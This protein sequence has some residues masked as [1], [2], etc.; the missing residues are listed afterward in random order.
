[1]TRPDGGTRYRPA[2]FRIVSILFFLSGFAGLGYQIIWFKRFSYLWG[3]STLAMAAVVASFLTGLGLGA[4]LLGKLADRVR[5]P[6][7]WYGILEA[8][9]AILALLLP[10]EIRLLT[11]LYEYLYPYLAGQVLSLSAVK[12]GLTFLLLGPPCLLMGGTLPLMLRYFTPAGV[13]LKEFS[14]WLYGLNTLGA[15]TGCYLTGFHLLPALGLHQLNILLAAL[16]L[17]IAAAA[18]VVVRRPARSERPPAHTSSGQIVHGEELHSAE[19]WS[20]YLVTAMTGCAALILEVVW[21]RQLALILG[22]S[23]YAFTAMLFPVLVGIGLGSLVFHCVLA[24]LRRLERLAPLVILGLILSVAVGKWM[25]PSLTAAVGLLKPLRAFE[26]YNG[27]ICVGAS[28]V[29][30]FLP[31]VGMGILFPLF[32]H[33]TRKRAR[34][35]GQ[36]VGVVYGLNIV[37]SVLGSAGASLLLIPRLGLSLSVVVGLLLYSGALVLLF[38]AGRGWRRWLALFACFLL[39]FSA[40]LFSAADVDPRVTNLGMYLYGYYSEQ[41]RAHVEIGYFQEGAAANVLVTRREDTVSLRINGKVEASNT[42]DMTMQLALAYV[43][44]ML[45][46]ESERVLIIGL[47]S[48]T[49]PGAALQFPRTRVTCCEIEPAVL[50]ASTFF[51]EVNHEPHLNPRFSFVADDGRSFLQGTDETFDLILSEPSNPWL[52]GVSNLFTQEFYRLAKKKLNPDGI[53]AQ[54]IQAYSFS[55]ADYRLI[56]RT[57]LSVFPDAR[58]VRVTDGDSILLAYSSRQARTVQNVGEI[59]ALVDSLP[60]VQSDLE[61]HFGSSDV[62]NIFQSMILVGNAGLN[63]MAGMDTAGDVN[64]DINM[65]LEFGTPVSLF[66]GDQAPEAVHDEILSAVDAGWIRKLSLELELTS[67]H[68]GVLHRLAG[69]LDGEKRPVVVRQIVQLGLELDPEYPPL[70]VDR[71]IYSSDLDSAEFDDTVTLLL[72]RSETQTSRLAR[73][74]FESED[75]EQSAAV[76]HRLTR[77]QPGSATAWAYLGLTYQEIGSQDLAREA[78]E[79]ALS[80]DPLNSFAVSGYESLQSKSKADQDP[81]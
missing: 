19:L 41:E 37:G 71:L 67:R 46:P 72:D 6:L 29:L 15:A 55:P 12:L 21:T 63:R 3:N 75:L 32:I 11:P 73:A 64:T 81:K 7:W 9:V 5:A 36:A 8:G 35:A 66:R 49:T 68:A 57:V 42:I 61:A 1:M 70:L 65:R 22:G 4:Y 78:F 52:A 62:K 43:P 51:S 48:G 56:V 34:D 13:A 26:A 69:L 23:V 47:G 17:A 39:V 80:L 77:A 10:L 16:N 31:S 40:C 33:L 28:G 18:V 14:G 24:P 38:P 2:F 53:L 50:T 25:I 74:L 27:L 58:L 79:K 59:Q 54:W 20:L 76:L 45:R 30:E 44:L 60:V